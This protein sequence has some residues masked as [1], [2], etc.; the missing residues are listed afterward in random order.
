LPNA[1]SKPRERLIAMLVHQIGLLERHIAA[2]TTSTTQKGAERN[3]DFHSCIKLR[4][5]MS[6]NTDKHFFNFAVP[7]GKI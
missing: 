7:Y 3:R 4:G 6:F 2:L 1:I 5:I